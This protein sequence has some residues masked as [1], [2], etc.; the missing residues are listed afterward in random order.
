MNY[1]NFIIP[2]GRC[3][4]HFQLNQRT[5]RDRSLSCLLIPFIPVSQGKQKNV[6]LKNN[7]FII[8]SRFVFASLSNILLEVF[9]IFIQIISI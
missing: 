1:L 7:V 2:A 5:K 3:V 9:D 6:M 8:P 4:S